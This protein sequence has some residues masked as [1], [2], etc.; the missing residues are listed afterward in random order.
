MPQN[1]TSGIIEKLKPRKSRYIVTDPKTAG[2]AVVIST[3]GNKYYYYRYRPSGSRS[4]VEEPIGNAAT[5]SLKDARLAAAIKAGD[6][7][8]GINL[9]EQRL[10]RIPEANKPSKNDELQLFS[11]ID[12]YYEPYARTH[13]V[14]GKEIVRILKKEFEFIKDKPVDKIC[15]QDIEQWRSVRGEQVTF[16][17]L[18]LIY[19]YLK[20]CINTAF[21]HYKLIDRFELQT[22]T[23]KRKIN[24][25]V[26]PPK[27]RY[28]S[29]DEETRLLQ[30]L[31][32]RDTE[33]RAMRARYFEWQSKRNHGKRRQQLFS[34]NDYPDHITPIITLAYHTGFDIGDIF[35][36]HWEHVDFPNNQIRKVRNK[37]KHKADNPQPVVVPMSPKVSALLQQW[38]KQHG[39]TGRVFP[40]PRTGGRLDNI[41]KAWRSV[42][43][44]ADLKD[45][46]LKD[47]RHTFASWLAINGID[48]MQIRDLLGHTDVKT[49]QIYAHLCPRQ[50]ERAVMAVFS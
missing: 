49:T 28:L 33:L 25:R 29:K 17:R 2:L 7:A 35:D 37:T 34:D 4:I 1:L 20:A 12:K 40:S 9:K 27:I 45:F 48:I 47:L 21:K 11:Y 23:L 41:S 38:G 31:A 43:S 39:M 14:S 13:S 44:K 26:N 22:F 8:K 36:L 19:T 15:S 3:N 42:S 10:A 50:K 16:A 18:K 5:L 30:A 46:R 24:E 6:V 32:D